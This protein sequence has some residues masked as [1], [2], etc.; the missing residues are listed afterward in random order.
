ML[1][2]NQPCPMELERVVRGYLDCA[3]WSSTHTGDD[4]HDGDPLDSIDAQWSEDAQCKARETCE[5]FMRE[6]EQFDQ[7]CAQVHAREGTAEDYFG[8]D[9]WL[10]RNHHGCGF[11]DR[12][13]VSKELGK[14]LTDRAHALGEVNAYWNKEEGTL[15]LD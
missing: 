4:E 3:A 6:R 8:S 10:T 1:N 5:L 7:Y 11:W 14:L 9:L 13:G 2:T 15:E 12:D